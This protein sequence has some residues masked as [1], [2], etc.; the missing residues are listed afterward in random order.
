MRFVRL[1]ATLVVNTSQVVYSRENEDGSVLVRCLGPSG[2]GYH[3]LKL[4]G[5][6]AQAWR[7]YLASAAA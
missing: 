5:E 3:D 4:E 2:G 6:E 7:D 1:S